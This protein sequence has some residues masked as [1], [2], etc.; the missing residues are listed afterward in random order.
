M[1]DEK[2]SQ[3]DEETVTDAVEA[4]AVEIIDEVAGEVDREIKNKGTKAEKKK[5]DRK[6]KLLFRAL[7]VCVFLLAVLSLCL[8]FFLGSPGK[9]NKEIITTASLQK[10]LDVS[11]LSTFEAVYNG[12]AKV[13]NEKNAEKVDYYVSYEATVKAGIDFSQIKISVDREAKKILIILPRVSLAEPN[14][15]IGTLDYIFVNNKAN[16]STVSEQAYKQCIEDARQESTAEKE[17][18]ELATQNAHNIVE[19]LVKPFVEQ[20][21]ADYTIEIKEAQE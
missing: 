10:I 9:E 15:D 17:I 3:T 7:M 13:M 1:A 12:I 11:E 21:D 4:E 6:E 19:A 20:G 5:R 8:G 18:Y 14:V 16:T 2:A